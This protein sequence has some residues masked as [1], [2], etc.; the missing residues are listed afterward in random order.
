[1]KII[2]LISKI[3]SENPNRKKL[4]DL[5]RKIVASNDYKELV[6]LTK[7]YNEIKNVNKTKK[8]K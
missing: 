5:D 1:M 4:K 7:Q 2:E 3:F 8:N 6:I